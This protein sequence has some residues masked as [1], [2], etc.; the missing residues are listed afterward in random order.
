MAKV[1]PVVSIITVP[2]GTRNATVT[3]MIKYGEKI[4]VSSQ[5]KMFFPSP[6]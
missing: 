5:R 6:Q 1:V 3:A 4:R 2:I